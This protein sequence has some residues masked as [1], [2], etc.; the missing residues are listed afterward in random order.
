MHATSLRVWELC[1]SE[2]SWWLRKAGSTEPSLALC[3][4]LGLGW[5]LLLEFRLCPLPNNGLWPGAESQTNP[6]FQKLSFPAYF[7][8]AIEWNCS[9]PSIFEEELGSYINPTPTSPLLNWEGQMSRGFLIHRCWTTHWS[10][11]N[12]PWW[13]KQQ[14]HPAEMYLC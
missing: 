1:K 13:W 6:V 12:A 5:D 3:P 7:T 8:T 2:E 10:L 9:P 11:E 4:W 14:R